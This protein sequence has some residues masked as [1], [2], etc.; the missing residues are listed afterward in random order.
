MKSRPWRAILV[1][2][3]VVCCF[4][5]LSDVRLPYEIDFIAR[6]W[7]SRLVNMGVRRRRHCF[8]AESPPWPIMESN[9]SISCR[10]WLWSRKFLIRLKTLFSL[11]WSCHFSMNIATWCRSLDLIPRK[12]GDGSGHVVCP[13]SAFPS[14]SITIALWSLLVNQLNG[15]YPMDLMCNTTEWEQSIESIRFEPRW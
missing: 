13:K 1:W 14:K 15:L 6:S 9:V 8:S 12:C 11:R 10:G 3:T 5:C 7:A 2:K 4:P